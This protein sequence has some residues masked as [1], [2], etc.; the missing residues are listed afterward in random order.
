ME[1][2]AGVVEA[3]RRGVREL[4]E[5]ARRT[6]A[7]AAGRGAAG[8]EACR[9]VGAGFNERRDGHGAAFLAYDHRGA[10]S[11]AVDERARE[12]RP[13]P[14][15]EPDIVAE[16]TV[17][18]G[19]VGHR[20]H[21]RRAGVAGRGVALLAVD[22]HEL[23]DHLDERGR[24]V[25]RDLEQRS[26][27]ALAHGDERLPHRAGERTFLREHLAQH[28][29]ERVE[30]G[31][32]VGVDAFLERLGRGVRELAAELVALGLLPVLELGLGDAE[33]GDLHLAAVG[34]E[35]V[36]RRHV[37][38]HEAGRGAIDACRV[39]EVEPAQYL[40]GDVHRHVDGEPPAVREDELLEVR[41]FHELHH[42]V[43]LAVLVD[44]VVEDLRDVLV[45]ELRDEAGLGL[46]VVEV[47]RGLREHAL[48]DD[49]LL[50]P[51][52]ALVAREPHLA[53]AACADAL[54]E[55]VTTNDAL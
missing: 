5:H 7:S 24:R 22:V 50:K 43:V 18:D 55:R 30:V 3:L 10:R 26:Y 53:H 31:A 21:Q 41:A 34:H 4:L 27:I 35:D 13:A 36:V 23:L 51:V 32:A 8:R 33:V 6:L 9:I 16:W 29:S 11:V 46:E 45:R 14:R 44:E 15:D 12:A 25:R 1:V 19:P 38:V 54:A 49:G 48:H 37:A 20:P 52:G 2:R 47:A 42:D 17:G 40:G 28:D 39:C